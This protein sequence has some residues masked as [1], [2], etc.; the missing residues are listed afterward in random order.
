MGQRK[1]QRRE[2][3]AAE[4]LENQTVIRNRSGVREV[5]TEWQ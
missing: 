2:M 1:G 5:K 4:G 3:G